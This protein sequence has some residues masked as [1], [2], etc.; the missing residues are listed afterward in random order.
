MTDF[1]R[2]KEY[3]DHEGERWSWWL[4]VDGNT[5]ELLKFEA[6]L[7]VLK[8]ASEFDLDYTLYPEE[9]EPEE[10]VDKLVEYAEHN[11][12]PVHNK[13]PGTFTCPPDLGEDAYHLYKGGIVYYF[14][15]TTDD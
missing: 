7:D 1:V 3:N 5:E 14:K 6:M 13:V 4:Q 8:D 10:V 15:E 11:Y 2:F 12:Y 9:I